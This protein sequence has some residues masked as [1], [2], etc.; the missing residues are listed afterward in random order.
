VQ[1][2]RHPIPLSHCSS[3]SRIPFPQLRI[4]DNLKS[5][6][7]KNSG[8]VFSMLSVGVWI[9]CVVWMRERER[10]GER[11]RENIPTTIDT[12]SR[13]KPKSSKTGTV[14]TTKS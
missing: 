6:I 1:L 7:E 9:V 10:E 2:G 12:V 3:M 11:K 14:H 13:N 8:V 4:K 5:L